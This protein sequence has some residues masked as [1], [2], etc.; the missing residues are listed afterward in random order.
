MLRP[1]RGLKDGALQ[2]QQELLARDAA[3]VLAERAVRADDAV[4]GDDDRDGGRAARRAGRAH[5]ARVSGVLGEVAV[6]ADLAVADAAQALQAAALELA[7]D[8]AE[9]DRQVEVLA[10]ALEVLVELAA[11][12]VEL[13]RGLDH[14]RGE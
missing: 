6:G 13:R 14:A 9:V 8:E 1:S 7:P 10:P 2:A 12:V 5:R 4:A 11:D 3:A